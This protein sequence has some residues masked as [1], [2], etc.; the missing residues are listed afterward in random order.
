MINTGGQGGFTE[1]DFNDL[2]NPIELKRVYPDSP[3]YKEPE[4]LFTIKELKKKLE[5]ETDKN[6]IHIFEKMIEH[7]EKNKPE[8]I[9]L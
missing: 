6:R 7:Q 5:T 8:P 4:P 3:D 9:K 1:D 2:D